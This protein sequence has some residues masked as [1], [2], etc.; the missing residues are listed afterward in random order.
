[1]EKTIELEIVSPVKQVYKGNVRSVSAPGTLGSFQVL[2]NHAPMVSTF[3]IGIVKAET[4]DSGVIE[5]AT[6]GGVFEVKKNKAIVL[7]ETIESKDDIDYERAKQAKLR[8]EEIMKLEDISKLE[9]ERVKKDLQRA[10]NR[11]KL[12]EKKE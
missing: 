9:K 12:F 7:A 1:M 10:E 5:Y 4:E 6:S 8:A 2:Y 3:G 11:L